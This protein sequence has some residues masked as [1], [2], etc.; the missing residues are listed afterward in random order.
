MIYEGS[1][2]FHRCFEFFSS[3]Y[4][5]IDFGDVHRVMMAVLGKVQFGDVST[6]IKFFTVFIIIKAKP[7]SL[8]DS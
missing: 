4:V 5:H 8:L 1:N 3:T 7:N 6:L 2:F